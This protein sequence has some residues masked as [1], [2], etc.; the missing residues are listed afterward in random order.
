MLQQFE[1]SLRYDELSVRSTDPINVLLCPVASF[2]R[3]AGDELEL[4]QPLLYKL[5][6]VKPKLWFAVV[7]TG[8]T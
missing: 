6:V 1:P 8:T 3:V 7:G 2:V 4:T 5:L